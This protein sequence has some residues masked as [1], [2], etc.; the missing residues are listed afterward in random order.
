MYLMRSKFLCLSSLHKLKEVRALYVSKRSDISLAIK[1]KMVI[2]LCDRLLIHSSG[3]I[4]TGSPG[5]VF[6]TNH[7]CFDL[8][9]LSIQVRQNRLQVL[10]YLENVK[11]QPSMTFAVSLLNFSKMEILLLQINPMAELNRYFPLDGDKMEQESPM[12]E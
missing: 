5:F 1:K 4:Y 3:T 8:N 2:H 11:W 10:S 12:Y 6:F 7:N 9:L